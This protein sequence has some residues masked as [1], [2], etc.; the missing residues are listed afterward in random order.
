VKLLIG[1][2]VAGAVVAGVPGAAQAQRLA[3]PA[4]AVPLASPVG[5]AEV[6]ILV[7]WNDDTTPIYGLAFRSGR[8]ERRRHLQLVYGQPRGFGGNW[9][10]GGS[11]D[12]ARRVAG[13]TGGWLEAHGGAQVLFDRRDDALHVRVPVGVRGEHTLTLSQLLATPVAAAGASA[14]VVRFGDWEEYGGV[15]GEAG[16]RLELFGA[17]AQGTV[18]LEQRLLG[19]VDRPVEP[20]LQLRFGFIRRPEN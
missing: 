6:A 1:L 5:G 4:A 18:A 14:G 10:G 20:R 15:Y 16:L 13:G 8:A 3:P 11:Y 12:M 7:Q 19:G 9:V 17:W 2:V